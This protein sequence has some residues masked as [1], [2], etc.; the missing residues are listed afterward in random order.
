MFVLVILARFKISKQKVVISQ[1]HMPNASLETGDKGSVV[2]NCAR[3]TTPMQI[4][5]E[6]PS[7]NIISC[8]DD[9]SLME[10]RLLAVAIPQNDA[11]LGFLICSAMYRPHA[12]LSHHCVKISFELVT[13]AVA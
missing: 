5:A 2:D 10:F 4:C 11:E 7:Q 3:I 1:R 8:D 6:G 9:Y 13:T 12:S